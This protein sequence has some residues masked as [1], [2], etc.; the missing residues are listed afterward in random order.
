MVFKSPHVQFVSFSIEVSAAGSADVMVIETDL[1]LNSR[2]PA[3]NGGAVQRL[4]AAV[5]SVQT[6]SSEVSSIRT[7]FVVADVSLAVAVIASL[8]AVVLWPRA[9]DGG[10]SR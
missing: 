2:H 6:T 9:H 10:S 8:G 1:H 4:I 3:Y 7:R 5:A